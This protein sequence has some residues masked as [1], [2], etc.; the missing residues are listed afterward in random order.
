MVD[1]VTLRLQSPSGIVD[2]HSKR[3]ELNCQISLDEE[4]KERLQHDI[5]V[6]SGKLRSVTKSLAQRLASRAA[7]D[8]TITEVEAEYTNVCFCLMFI[9]THSFVFYRCFLLLCVL[10]FFF[11]S[12][13]R[14]VSCNI[15]KLLLLKVNS[16]PEKNI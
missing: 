12:F 6:L 8:F 4:D 11:F 13:Q 7:F 9:I 15:V 10:G 16:E 1:T 14:R 3:E 2:L 5:Q